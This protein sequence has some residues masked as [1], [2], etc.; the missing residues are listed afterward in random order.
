MVHYYYT[1]TNSEHPAIFVPFN[2]KI[3]ETDCIVV[4]QLQVVMC[5]MFMHAGFWLLVTYYVRISCAIAC[6]QKDSYLMN[7][8]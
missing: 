1:E 4:W 8:Y 5:D 7:A 6:I 3:F 2:V